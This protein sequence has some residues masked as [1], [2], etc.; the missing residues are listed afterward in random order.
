MARADDLTVTAADGPEIPIRVLVPQQGARGVIVYL[1]GGGWVIGTIDEYDTLARKLAERTSCAVVLVDYRLAP[2]HRYPTAVDDCDA[3]L[4]W[5]GEHLADIAGRD[6]VPLIVAGDSAGG[7]LAAVMAQRARDRGGPEIALQVLI[8][9]VTDADFDRPSYAD[10]DNQLLLTREAM[11]WFWDHYVPNAAHRHEADASPLRAATLAGLPP[12]VVLT[13][14]HDVL[15]DEGE[16]YAERLPEAGVPSTLAATPARPTASSRSC[17]CPAASAAS[18]TWSRRC[19]PAPSP[20][21]SSAPSASADAPPRRAPHET[22]RTQRHGD[23]HGDRRGRRRRDRRRLRRHVHE[24]PPARPDGHGRPGVR[25]R[26]RRRR[27]LVLE[28]LP[29]RPLRLR[30]VHL[31]LLLRQGPDAGLGVERQVPGAAG[32]PALP[33]P[34]R[35]PLRHP[36]QHQV[37]DPGDGRPLG[38]GDEPLD[39]QDG[40]GRRG[41][42]PLPRHRRRLPV[43]RAGAQDP[44][45][46]LV[47]GRLVPHRRLAPRRRRLH[48]QARRRHRHGVERRAVDPGD[49]RPGRSPHRVPAH[50]AVHGPGP[51]RHR[52]Q[53]VPRRRQEALRRH[54]RAVPLVPRRAA[55]HAAGPLGAGGQ[56]RGARRDLRGRLAG[57][58]LQVHPH[59]VQRHQRRPPGQRHRVGVHPQQD[60]R[61]GPRPRGGREARPGRPPV[62]VEAGADRH[63]LLRHVQPRQRHARRHPPRADRGDHAD[64]DPHRRRRVRARHHR[65]RHRLRRDDRDV[66]QDGHPGP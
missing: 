34:R 28:P 53:G 56:R 40:P 3:A 61:D 63:Q 55:V 43:E 30:V 41:P 57:G 7:N 4:T 47:P 18:S 5:I 13:A 10:P 37:R 42:R 19:G 35:R 58:R 26:R 23:R 12:A 27:H 32:D 16:A 22:R 6:D 1:H 8:Y 65:V 51:P 25:G 29:R 24:L 11:V 39:R 54:L 14:E 60:P 52:R 38:R 9:P 20:T 49:R 50:A 36:P 2:E 64:G 62:H 48:R 46:R 66:Q 44:R 59:D 15:R 17:C 45:P 33:E 31:L 21:P